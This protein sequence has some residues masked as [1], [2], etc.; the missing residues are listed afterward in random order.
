MNASVD[1]HPCYEQ[2]LILGGSIAGLLAAR[3]LSEHFKQ[4]LILERDR[5]PDTPSPRKGTPQARHGHAVLAK[6]VLIF[7]QLFPGFSQDL[8]TQ[9]AIKVDMCQDVGFF[10]FGRWKKRFPSQI[11]SYFQTRTFLEWKLR[12]R[13]AA[14]PNVTFCDQTDV[15]GFTMDDAKTRVTGLDLQHRD[16]RTPAQAQLTADLVV[17]ASGRGSRTPQWLEA[18]GYPRVEELAVAADLG[19]STCFF[20]RTESLPKEWKTLF[21]FPELPKKRLGVI[22]PTE[23]PNQWLVTLGGVFGDYPPTDPAGFLE[24]ARSL[25]QPELYQMIKDLEPV[26]AIQTYKLPSNLRRCYERMSRFPEGLVVLGDALCSFNPIYG[27]GMTTAALDGLALG[28]CLEEQRRNHPN[29]ELTGLSRRFRKEAAAVIANPWLMA[30]A[31]DMRYPELNAQA[32]PLVRFLHWF[33]G[34]VHTVSD[35]D[36]LSAFRF[37]QAMNML[38][39]PWALFDPRVVWQAL[40]AGTTESD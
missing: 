4:V 12:Q 15:Q 5:L 25:P 19:Y 11:Y 34:R 17:D 7:E 21:V 40:T 32:T 30:T 8:E 36:A 18:F 16:G 13:V 31:E 2:V 20:R 26:G 22:F 37:A 39:P 24:F 38:R 27:Q 9:G 29:G 14:I 23:D 35:R 33:T 6:A 3:I 10:H 1:R 28:R